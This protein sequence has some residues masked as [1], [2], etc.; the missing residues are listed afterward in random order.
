MVETNSGTS[1][2][3]TTRMEKAFWI[4]I[5]YANILILHKHTDLL[6]LL[7]LPSPL[8]LFF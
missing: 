2:H 4:T 7:P 1:P 8:V 5:F 6:I 3:V